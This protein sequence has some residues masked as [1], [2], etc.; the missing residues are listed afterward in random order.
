M[1]PFH[2][3]GVNIHLER[4][5]SRKLSLTLDIRTLKK[6]GTEKGCR[7]S[8]EVRGIGFLKAPTSTSLLVSKSMSNENMGNFEPNSQLMTINQEGFRRCLRSGHS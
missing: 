8:N 1:S 6:T 5:R 3:A 2:L 7:V 4:P